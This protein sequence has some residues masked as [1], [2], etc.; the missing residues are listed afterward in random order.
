MQFSAPAPTW[1]NAFYAI[2]GGRDEQLANSVA[3]SRPEGDY[4][5]RRGS[6]F[7]T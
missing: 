3:G 2:N 1:P 4:L 7:D 5:A 6:K